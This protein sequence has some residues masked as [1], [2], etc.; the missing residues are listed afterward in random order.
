MGSW[1]ASASPERPRLDGGLLFGL[2]VLA[3]PRSTAL[4]RGELPQFGQLAFA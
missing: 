3:R 1:V 4:L 2:G